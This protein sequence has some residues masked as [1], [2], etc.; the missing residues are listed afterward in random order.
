MDGSL[1]R[2]HFWALMNEGAVISG[3]TGQGWETRFHFSR[4]N[5]RVRL[6]ERMVNAS[7]TLKE[8]AKPFPKVVAH[9]GLFQPRLE[10]PT[11]VHLCQQ[12]VFAGL[13][14]YTF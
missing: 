5:T 14:V 6:L 12:M 7:L 4:V 2:V 9:F 11:A 13:Y 10:V 8:T 3:N 1:N